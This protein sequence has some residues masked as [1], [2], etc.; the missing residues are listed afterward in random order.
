MKKNLLIPFLVLVAVGLP[1]LA[2]AFTIDIEAYFDG[3]D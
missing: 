2:A 3:R 1:A